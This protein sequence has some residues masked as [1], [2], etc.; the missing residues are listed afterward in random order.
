[1]KSLTISLIIL[2]LFTQ[3]ANSADEWD[4][5]DITLA[6][7]LT[8][9]ILIDW[10]QTRDMAK[11]NKAKCKNLTNCRPRYSEKNIILGKN[12]S[13]KRVD[14]Y[15]PLAIATTITASNYL[16]RYTRKQFLYILSI[17]ELG[18][19]FKNKKMDLKINF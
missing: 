15:M 10:G 7:I 2:F 3:N 4:N 16:P 1:M 8:T 6:S 18:L 5:E 13:L 17:I 14:I 12:P 9:T 11:K 19:I